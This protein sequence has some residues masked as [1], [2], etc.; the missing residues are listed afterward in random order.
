MTP[1]AQR[2]QS[3]YNRTAIAYAESGR[4]RLRKGQFMMQAYPETHY[5][6]EASARRQYNKIMEGQTSG[7]KIERRGRVKYIGGAEVGLWKVTVDYDYEDYD[8]TWKHAARSF[9]MQSNEYTRLDDVP[10][11]YAILPPIIERKIL[12]WQETGSTPSNVANIQAVVQPAMRSRV[13]EYQRI[14]LDNVEIG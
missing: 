3:A 10:Y 8:G 1:F 12:E 9:S 7:V 4:G 5:K 2:L 14:T 13:H 11:I 6:N